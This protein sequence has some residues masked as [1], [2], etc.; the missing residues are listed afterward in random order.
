MNRFKVY[1]LTK[2][3]NRLRQI[4]ALTARRNN[5]SYIFRGT[6]EMVRMGLSVKQNRKLAELKD[7]RNI[8]VNESINV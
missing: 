3:I 4:G 2:R 5:P 6:E 8:L 1:I 7:R